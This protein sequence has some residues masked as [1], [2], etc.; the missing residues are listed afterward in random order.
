MLSLPPLPVLYRALEED[1]FEAHS[2]YYEREHGCEGGAPSS[3]SSSRHQRR[4]DTDVGSDYDDDDDDVASDR[5]M[6]PPTSGRRNYFLPL[7]AAAAVCFVGYRSYTGTITAFPGGKGTSTATRDSNIVDSGGSNAYLSSDAGVDP[8]IPMLSTEELRLTA[9]NEYGVYDGPYPWLRDGSG[10]QL[11]EPLKRT[12]LTASGPFL[13]RNGGEELE[14]VW[15]VDGYGGDG[16]TLMSMRKSYV[17]VTL[18]RPGN[19]DV[20][21]QLL[22]KTTGQTL[23]VYTTRLL[24]RYVKR[25][26]RS[27]TVSDRER[28][29]DAMAALWTHDQAAGEAK[30][31]PRFTSIETFVAAHSVASNDIMCDQ[32]HEGTGFL[33]HHL[34]LTNSFEASLR[35]VDPSVTLP[36]WDFT[37]E[38]QVITNLDNSPSYLVEITPVFTDE[39]FGSVDADNHIADSRWAHTLMPRQQDVAS[40]VRNS[41]GFIRSYWNNNPDP[42]VSRHLFD[43]CG[44]EA[45]HKKI[46]ACSNHFDLLNARTLGDF[47]MLAPAD[48]HGPMHVQIGGMWGGCTEGYRAFYTKWAHVLEANVTNKEVASLGYKTWKWGMRAPRKAMVETAIMGEYFHIYRSLWRSHMCA[49]DGTPGLLVC[50]DACPEG[51]PFDECSCEVTGLLTGETTWRNLLPCLLNSAE[52][53]DFFER[54]MPVELL[55]DLTV[56]VATSSVQEGEMIESASTADVL[57]W[58]IHPSIERLLAAKRLPDVTSMNGFA[59]AQWPDVSGRNESWLQYSYYDL[60]RKQNPFMKDAYTCYGHAEN[61][62]VFPVAL[63]LTEAMERATDAN[64]DGI[65]TN[66]E[67]FRALDPNLP[68][69]NDYVFDN[70]DWAHCDRI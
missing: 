69:S 20:R 70:F 7:V 59:F 56:M 46:P 63:P 15:Q 67:F 10:A 37:V 50:P 25:E 1:G 64:T 6:A 23:A 55:E 49:Q 24:C 11:V 14:F 38:G 57:F 48:G 66:V 39:W 36:Y 45:L 9:T 41:Y 32:F 34:A 42:E 47:L 68:D 61:D 40:G 54:T 26:I 62:L 5:S 60:K 31:G 19:Y 51:T 44:V 12:T 22:S 52:N 13:N 21:V 3:S 65:V 18:A 58:M 30:Y 43:A 4:H 8:D 17:E 27:L 29:L 35:S 33:T 2:P 28:L 16:G 53:R